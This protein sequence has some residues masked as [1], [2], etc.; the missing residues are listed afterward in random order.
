[1]GMGE[2]SGGGAGGAIQLVTRNL[3]GTGNF[4]ARG[5]NGSSGGGGGGAG[6]RF[7]INYLR[8][9]VASA[10]PEQSHFW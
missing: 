6:G 3:K 1:M 5:G 8:G 10:Q 4:L 2:G 9:Y 7:V